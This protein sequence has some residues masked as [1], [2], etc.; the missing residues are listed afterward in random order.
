D[1]ID[2]LL[3]QLATRE[4]DIE[5]VAASDGVTRV[6]LCLPSWDDYLA[7]ALD[8]IIAL[9]SLSPNVTGRLVRLLDGLAAITPPNRHPSL[10]ARRQPTQQDAPPANDTRT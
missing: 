7:V 10:H 1:A 2:G 9:P 6:I 3:R 4:L 5:R 8:E